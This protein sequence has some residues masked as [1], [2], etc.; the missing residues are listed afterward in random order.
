LI[1]NKLKFQQLGQAN[2]LAILQ[3]LFDVRQSAL[4]A[5]G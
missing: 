2:Q 3:I 1:I 5:T 4:L